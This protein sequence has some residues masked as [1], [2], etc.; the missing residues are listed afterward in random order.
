[1]S[2]V[3]IT[4]VLTELNGVDFEFIYRKEVPSLTL[5]GPPRNY[6]INMDKVP[7]G[8]GTHWV[9]LVVGP[10]YAFYH[11]PFGV[12]PSTLIQEWMESLFGPH[13][14]HVAVAWSRG[15]IQEVKSVMCGWYVCHFLVSMNLP[16][17]RGHLSRATP[18]SA[19]AFTAYTESWDPYPSPGNEKRVNIWRDQVN[20]M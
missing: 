4:S 18:S 17:I 13:P 5:G 12:L 10:T 11:D 6:V 20:A 14:S 19:H 9:G 16:V 7:H 2:S 1:M 15:Q 3:D 8:Q